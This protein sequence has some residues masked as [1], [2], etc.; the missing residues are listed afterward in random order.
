MIDSF[1]TEVEKKIIYPG[2]VLYENVLSIT[3]DEIAS[4]SDVYQYIN[5]NYERHSLSDVKNTFFYGFKKIGREKFAENV[6]KSILYYLANYCDT[7]EEAIHTIQWQEN[8]FIDIEFAGEKSF[9]YNTNKSFMD[10]DKIRSTP[11]SRQISVEVCIDDN[12]IGG[13]LEWP[14]L[15][16]LKI[17][18][19]NKG[20]IL[21]YPSNYLFSTHHNSILEGRRITLTTFFNGGKDFLAEENGIEESKAQAFSYMR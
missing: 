1:S 19:I 3:D 7:Y 13:S 10:N 5:K 20:S 2:I 18:K 16:Q 15:N 11:F 4:C 9:I 21:Y 8:I 14:Y 17:N 6:Q 12:Y